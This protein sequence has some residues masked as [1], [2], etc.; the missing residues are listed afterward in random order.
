ML[1]GEDR[2]RQREVV[3]D[4]CLAV[5]D[6][7]RRD[8]LIA[9]VRERADDGVEVEPVLRLHVLPHDGQSLLVEGHAESR[10]K[11]SLTVA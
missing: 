1:V 7:A 8:E 11:H 3:A 10:S 4:F 6:V 2:P 9:R 5:E